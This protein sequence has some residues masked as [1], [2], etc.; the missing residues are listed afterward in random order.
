MNLL[1]H[2]KETVSGC[3]GARIVG[4][5]GTRS[6]R[7]P[8]PAS[9]TP[10]SRGPVRAGGGRPRDTVSPR[11]LPVFTP[12]SVERGPLDPRV[13]SGAERLR[14]RSQEGGVLGPRWLPTE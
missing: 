10:P 4:G 8:T 2:Y 9:S 11:L 7:L 12:V 6:S 14:S 1:L 3:P 5:G 13:C